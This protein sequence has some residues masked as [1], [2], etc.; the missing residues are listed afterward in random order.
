M[1]FVVPQFIDVES[2][3]IGPISARQFIILIVA[4]GL[5]F[6]WY[7]LFPV[8]VFIPVIVFTVAIAGGL[9]FARVNSQPMHYFLLNLLQTLKQP[10]LKVWA[11]TQYLERDLDAPLPPPPPRIDK[12][13]VTQSRL[14]AL[15][16]LVD[17]GGIYAGE[18]LPQQPQSVQQTITPKR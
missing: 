7:K 3:I 14:A 10:R 18:D 16:L 12:G 1:Q 2:K 6:V 17:T 9:A 8:V 4:V 5:S 15:S 11:R 13:P